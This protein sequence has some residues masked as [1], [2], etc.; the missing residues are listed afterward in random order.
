MIQHGE[1]KEKPAGPVEIVKCPCGKCNTYGLSDG[2][3]YAGCGWSKERAQQYADAINAAD[4]LR[5]VRGEQGA[6]HYRL[7]KR[8]SA[9]AGELTDLRSERGVA[10]TFFDRADAEYVLALIRCDQ[11]LGDEVLTGDEV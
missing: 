4:R 5:S 1:D 9:V 11:L 10:A 2:L 8:D 6:L 7:E 3:F